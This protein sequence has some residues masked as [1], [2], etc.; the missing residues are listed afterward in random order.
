MSK[1]LGSE[2]VTHGVR[3]AVRPFF[4]PEHTNTEDSRYAFGYRIRIT[5]EGE[6]AAKL[7]SRHWV[8]VDADG[9]RREIQGEGVVGQ[10]PYIPPGTTFEYASWCPL[11]TPW[12]TMEGSYVMQRDSGE[13]F[14]VRVARFYLATPSGRS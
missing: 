10:Q 2:V 11:E 12:G 3:V 5:N 14:E 13:T 6:A 4:L 8:I 1:T 7:L 9:A